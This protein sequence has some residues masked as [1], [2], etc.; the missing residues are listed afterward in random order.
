MTLSTRTPGVAR[1]TAL[2]A[3]LLVCGTGLAQDEGGSGTTAFIA[4][5]NTVAVGAGVASGDHRD[6]TRFGI[7][8]G[9][10]K[11]DSHLLLDFNFSRRDAANGRW[12][13]FS[14]RNL[15]LDSRELAVDYRTLGDF[16]LKVDYGELVRHDPRI[17]NTYL[18][19]AGTATPTVLANVTA[20]NQL[21][22]RGSEL[23]LELKRKGIGFEIQKQFG[24]YQ[25]EASFRNEDKNGARMFGIGMAC[26]ATYTGAGV[27]TAATGMAILFLPEPV[28]SNIKQFEAKLNYSGPSLKLTAGY[29]AN[30]YTSDFGS[31]R[32]TVSGAT[33]SNLNPN[34]AGVGSAAVDAL[35]RTSFMQQP[36]ALWPDS[37]AHQ[38]YIAGNYRLSPRTKMN[39]KASYTRA[40]QD[41]NFGAMGLT[42]APAGSSSLGGRIDTTRLQA[43]ISSHPWT[44]VH[45][46]G[47]AM[48]EH[49]SNKTKLAF[50]NTHPTYAQSPWTN[51]AMSPS[52]FELKGQAGYKLPHNLELIG[53]ARYERED[54][55]RWT[56]TDIAGGINGIREKLDIVAYRVELRKSMSEVFTGS[57]ALVSERREGA[58]PWL[59]VRSGFR[60]LLPADE[61]CVS[62]GANACIYQAGGE[63]AFTQENLQRDKVRLNANW[64]P[65]ERLGLQG[66]LEF[67]TD[68]FRGPTMS[69]LE[70]TGMYNASLD[71]DYRL[72]E[73]W[74][75]RAFI[76]ANQ[77]TYN[78]QRTGDFE[79]RMSDT[80]LTAGVGFTGTPTGVFKVGGDLMALRDVLNYMLKGQS[81][82]AITAFAATGG[83]PQ[84]K[85]TLLRANLYG[86]Y[87]INKA[88]TIRLDY[89]YH[90]TFFNEWTWEGIGNGFPFVFSDNTTVSAQQKQSVSFL[91]ARYIY[92]FQ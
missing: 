88:S 23:N 61:N 68:R 55:G 27:C 20:T 44:K 40:T 25:I 66:L 52:K 86:E 24:N 38:F 70:S 1:T 92:K 48:Y 37:Q 50:Y 16:R 4:E 26:S 8:N 85:Y 65:M 43:G 74:K 15:G 10:R 36:V 90:R 19:G 41:E 57:A 45:L 21:P 34:A 89:I 31:I 2:L 28:N 53:G 69:G 72:A 32:A 49:K 62:V 42:G 58:S 5:E 6:R 87:A 73:N 33:F 80:S 30:L 78:M 47:D 35:L 54:F 22:G 67:G 76:T 39:F 82:T 83:L 59:K 84:V 3:G 14:G 64:Q 46:V 91:G 71:A 75:L 63:F 17:V 60:G 81:A 51:S 11:D 29:Y 56:P 18:L 13:T 77:R 7:Y 79:L 12:F 9:L